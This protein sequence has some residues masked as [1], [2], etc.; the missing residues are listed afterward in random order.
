MRRMG[1]E[2]VLCTL[3]KED[4]VLDDDWQPTTPRM[5]KLVE[6][7][8]RLKE[9]IPPALREEMKRDIYGDNVTQNE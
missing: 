1:K 3:K 2:K 9:L 7:Q 8:K 4:L 5:K 6:L